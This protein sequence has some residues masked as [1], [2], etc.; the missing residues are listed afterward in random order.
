ML[1]GEG[2]TQHWMETANW[3]DPEQIS[4]TLNER[5]NPN[6]FLYDKARQLLPFRNPVNLW[7]TITVTSKLCKILASLWM[8][9]LHR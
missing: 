5:T 6:A 3:D 7:T 8:L 4:R 9:N 1:V 2:Q